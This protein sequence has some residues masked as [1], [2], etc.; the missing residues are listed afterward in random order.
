M[1]KRLRQYA[2]HVGRVTLH[3]SRWTLY[4]SAVVLVLLTITFGIARYLLPMITEQKTNLEQYLSQRSGHQVRIDSLHAYW[5]GLHPGA[6]VRGLQVF[7]ADGIRPAIR[8]S[9]VRISL[10]LLPLLWGNFE[11]N[12]LVVVNPSLALERLTDGRFR[13]SGFDPLA[14]VERGQDEKFVNWLFQ[15]G[16]LEIENGELQ[17]FDHR[18]TGA[19]LHLGRAN[20]S[21]RN[22]GDRHRLTFNADFPDGMCDECSLVLDVTGN[23][24]ASSDWDGDIY[25][26]AGHVNSSALPLIAR[27]KLPDNFRGKF[28]LQLQSDWEEGR[29]VS[30]RGYVKVADL[31]L[32][33]RGW[34]TPL[35]IRE[36]S[37]DLVWR[38]RR[39][40][41]RLDMANPMLGLNGP[42]WA[43]GHLRIEYQPDE[44]EIQIKH[45][46]LADVTGFV[47]RL[48]GEITESAKSAPGNAGA[49]LDAWLAAKPGGAVNNFSLRLAGDWMA[50][51]NYSLEADIK[52][53]AALA[54]RKYPGVQGLGGHLSLS[55]E[56][57]NFRIDSGNVKLSLPWVFRNPLAAQRVSGDLS[58]EKYADYWQ[59]NGSDLRVTAEDGRGTGKLSLQLPH[60]HAVS[61]VLKL[62][63]DFQGGNGAHAARYYPASH[64]TPGTLA[65][66][67]RSFVAGDITEGYL[68]YDGPIRDFPFHNR[69]GKFEL[70][71]HV[72]NGVYL[73]LPGWEPVKQA[74]V[75]VVIDG[76]EVTVIG[77]GKIGKLDASQVVVQSRDSGMGHHVVHVGGKVSGALNETLNVLRDVKPE[78]GSARWLA[79]VPG[80]MQ[81]SGTGIL[82]LDLTIPLSDARATHVEG[83]YRFMKNTLRF[84]GS[85]VAVEGVEGSV[86]FT[87]AGL[88]EGNLRA[89]F[90]GGETVLAA[91]QREGRLV[92]RGQG[93]VMAQGLTPIVGA[94]IAAR[95]SGSAGWSGTWQGRN[96]TGEL[97]ASA[98]LRGLK[99]ALPAPLDR[100]DGLADEKLVVR[101]ESARRDN[102]VLAFNVGSGMNGKLALARDGGNWKFAG[103]RIDFGGSA[104]APVP[105]T[106]DVYIRADVATV[107][108]DQWWPLLGGGPT[109]V[110]D[111]LVRISASVKTLN[112]F[113]RQFE[114][115]VTDFS[116][117][118]D[119]WQGTVNGAAMAGSVKYSGKGPTARFE[120][121][122]AH[123]V[124]PD[125]QYE[126]GEAS[127]DPRRL[128][129]VQLRS[130]SF[131]LRHKQLGE[132]DFMAEPVKSGW[133]IERFN[134]ARADMKLNAGGS[135]E[136]DGKNHESQF[137]IEFSSPDMGKTMEAFDAPDRLAG[138][139]VSVKSHLSWSGSPTNPHLAA[140]SGKV[141]VSAKKGRFLQVKAGAGRLFGLL[142]LSAI[143]R[144]LTLDFSPVFGKGL[145]YDRIQGEVNI[146]KGNAYTSGFSIRGPAT[147]LDVGGRVGLV[148]EDFDLA[149]E[150][151]PKISDTVTIATW[152][153]LGPQVAAAVLAVQKIFKKQI[154]KGT[155]ITYVVK[156][157]WENPTI[158]KLVKGDVADVPK[159]PGKADDAADVR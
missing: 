128:P 14:P 129:A 96:E 136:F 149:L 35:G 82:S 85:P 78:P 131:E 87:E 58:W 79:Y 152:G 15:Q 157:P 113:D 127:V 124:L 121:D 138:G 25:V 155:R 93:A 28:A 67:E 4:I 1:K 107:D 19:A 16:R 126:R 144:Y 119:V 139:E 130:K 88:H 5:D 13:I 114:N 153:V 68:I 116:R 34:D 43:A 151:Q 143:G 7:A 112:M 76:S 103:A 66:M 147:Q 83:E 90:L 80:G 159:E 135:W 30:V 64:L 10:A 6:R 122:L 46:D 117:S 100:P 24:L 142:D 47:T 106:R 74:E 134:L 22:N 99:L 70:R 140:L 111:F 150:L 20:L 18:E 101:T 158:T 52:D 44:S 109:E 12:S 2:F 73:F 8:L 54:W 91:A 71:G 37:G 115:I 69:T 23:P 81:G 33:I 61:P 98:D 95:I 39:A 62:R 36:A 60:D 41:W 65:W 40:G 120:M 42:P 141:N 45:V 49:L 31:R 137:D 92:V 29:P 104:P 123:L 59:V 53:G 105:K 48:K 89:R 21:L 146:E 75:D 77:S 63:V 55:R 102:M 145:L 17:W 56:T 38:T 27:E 86:R 72:R 108:A 125:A 26:R 57:G 156:G 9:E 154:A 11:I 148:A 84:A 118:R 32:P 110:P 50:P 3:V 132:L 94:K 51:E 133:R 97:V